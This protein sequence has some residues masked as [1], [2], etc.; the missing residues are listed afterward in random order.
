MTSLE[1]TCCGLVASQPP[2]T[3]MTTPAAAAVTT[4][5]FVRTQRG[6]TT[7]GDAGAGAKGSGRGLPASGVEEAASEGLCGGAA[8]TAGWGAGGGGASRW[9]SG[10]ASLLGRERVGRFASV[11]TAVL[12][13]HAFGTAAICVAVSVANAGAAGGAFAVAGAG[14][15]AATGGESADNWSASIVMGASPGTGTTAAAATARN[16]LLGVALAMCVARWIQR[17]QA[18]GP[19]L[20]LQYVDRGLNTRLLQ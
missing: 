17:V 11:T 6:C 2:A 20:T 9:T 1:A 7:G 12:S 3:A 13:C 14:K 19:V 16:R 5:R 8:I 10:V 4:V 15:R 18:P